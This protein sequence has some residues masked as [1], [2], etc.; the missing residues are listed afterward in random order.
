[1]AKRKG[2]KTYTA[3][4]LREWKQRLLANRGALASK[5]KVAAGAFDDSFDAA[6]TIR[7]AAQCLVSTC[8]A[9]SNIDMFIAAAERDGSAGRG[10]DPADCGLDA[11]GGAP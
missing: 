5:T 2:P 8:I 1:M 10:F 4:E 11:E 9:L 7:D 3:D 6:I